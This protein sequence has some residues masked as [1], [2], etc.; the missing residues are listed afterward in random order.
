MAKR[1]AE[2]H[3]EVE[4]ACAKKHKPPST[5]TPDEE[6]LRAEVACWKEQ[7][8]RW[9]AEA[10][11]WK[12]KFEWAD[13]KQKVAL[14]HPEDGIVDLDSA[15][16]WNFRLWNADGNTTPEMV[17]TLVSLLQH[18]ACQLTAMT[19]LGL[20]AE[21]MV[22]LASALQHKACKLTALYLQREDDDGQELPGLNVAALGPALQHEACR[23][24]KLDLSKNK[25]QTEGIVA[26]ASALQ[27]GACRLTDLDLSDNPLGPRGLETLA[28]ALGD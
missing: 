19:I 25:L 2:A 15:T 10:E 22:P 20:R 1:G 7:A 8:G 5:Q 13:I 23:L 16:D 3:A 27:H 4:A 11:S 17:A 28:P 12:K 6:K 21:D 9:E 24:T 26:I 14:F 18:E